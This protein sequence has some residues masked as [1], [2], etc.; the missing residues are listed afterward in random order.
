MRPFWQ[1]AKFRENLAGY[2]FILPNLSGYLI[3][4]LLPI[5]F[6]L[7][8]VFVDWEYLKGFAGISW[9]GFD[10]FKAL[11]DDPK[12]IK[13]LQNNT[14][15]TVVS[16]PA[17]I[18]FGLIL[19]VILNQYV[20]AKNTLRTLIFLPYVSSL[21]AVSVIWSIM[22]RAS[23]GPINQFLLSIGI[24]HPPGWL[25]SPKSALFAI[26]IMSVWVTIGYAMVI[27]LAGLQGISKDLYEAAEIDGA[28]KLR[29]FIQITV[30]MLTPTTF[31]IAITLMIWSFQVFGPVAVMTQGGPIDSTMVLSYHI[32]LLAFRFYKMGYAAAVSWVLF[33]I[34]FIITLI[35]W[36]SQKRWQDHF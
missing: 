17:S 8:L 29:Q 21:V 4:I 23:N 35:Q 34:I 20:F 1:T 36:Q 32:Y 15:F 25:S 19:A 14:I 12:L 22:Y 27:Y 18:L 2:L 28:S 10:N 13:S 31:L 7:Y 6:S 5:L 26:I 33:T 16:V 30:P 3:F 11:L 9:V 24:E